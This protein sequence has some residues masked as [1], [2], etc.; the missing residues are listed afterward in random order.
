MTLHSNI[1]R[2]LKSS[3]NMSLVMYVDKIRSWLNE[4]SSNL[5]LFLKMIS[6]DRS[7][8]VRSS[9]GQK[10]FHSYF[11]C[12]PHSKLLCFDVF[13]FK[14]IILS[15]LDSQLCDSLAPL[16]SCYVMLND[17]HLTCSVS[18]SACYFDNL[19]PSTDYSR[20]KDIFIRF[21]YVLFLLSDIA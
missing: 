3:Q 4:W 2:F 19:I 1:S 15:F 13:P 18:E 10:S 5:N 11:I 7:C 6:K 8:L 14:Q 20:R 12:E 16:P 9:N 21:N 17:A